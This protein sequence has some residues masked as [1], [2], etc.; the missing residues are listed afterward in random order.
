SSDGPLLAAYHVTVLVALGAWVV[1]RRAVESLT[2]PGIGTI[3][4]SWPALALLAGLVAQDGSE[5]H[6]LAILPIV[7]AGFAY[8]L[9]DAV[10][11]HVAYV[12]IPVEV[13]AAVARVLDRPGDAILLAPAFVGAL[14]AS[15]FAH[16]LAGIRRTFARLSEVSG[17]AAWAV[18]A[19]LAF[20]LDVQTTV[21]WAVAGGVAVAW[22]L[23]RR[24]ATV[25]YV[26]FA[27]LFLLLGKVFLYDISGL[28]VAVRVLALI[29]VA[30]SLLVI[31]YGYARY[32]KRQAAAI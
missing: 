14:V 10:T 7:V 28:E 1:Y 12:L 3:R 4:I 17:S 15:G 13:I 24:Y 19:P 11:F 27:L 18:A 2:R 32:R 31:S 6:V 8:A 20:G 9:D 26:G 16:D 22:G 21:A 5:A 30:L 25:R 29:V 23:W